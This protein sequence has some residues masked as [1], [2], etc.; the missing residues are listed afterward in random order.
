MVPS[1]PL[2]NLMEK[3]SQ[4]RLFARRGYQVFSIQLDRFLSDEEMQNTLLRDSGLVHNSKL[5]MKLPPKEVSEAVE[6]EE[7]E[8]FDAFDEAMG[9]EGGEDEMIEF[10]EGEDEMSEPLADQED[11]EEE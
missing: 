4:Y 3:V 10:E 9:A 2:S 8:H 7:E 1:E 6:E 11:G 5:L